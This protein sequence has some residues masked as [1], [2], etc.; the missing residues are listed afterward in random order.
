ML[1]AIEKYPR[2][3]MRV[4]YRARGDR[5]EILHY[6][7]VL[8]ADG[9]Y[10]CSVGSR[11]KVTIEVIDRFIVDRGS[12]ISCLE[13]RLEKERRPD[14]VACHRPNLFGP[15]PIGANVDRK[16]RLEICCRLTNR[17]SIWNAIDELQ[18][19]NIARK[20]VR[21]RSFHRSIRDEISG[22]I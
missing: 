10:R 4:N 21:R 18:P 9:F 5:G 1:L 22:G 12:S 6:R 17:F 8:I 11:S 19:R 3:R 16:Y 15:F 2:L 7:C 20:Q 13:S 14:S